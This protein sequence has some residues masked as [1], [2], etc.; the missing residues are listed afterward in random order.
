[1]ERSAVRIPV[2]LLVLVAYALAGTSLAQESAWTYAFWTDPASG[3]TLEAIQARSTG[4]TN[5]MAVIACGVDGRPLL[6]FAAR[7]FQ[8]L[9]AGD[10]TVA[11]A[12]DGGE[13][14]VGWGAWSRE[15]GGAVLRWAGD[16]E[17]L[18]PFLTELSPARTLAVS[19]QDASGAEL[20]AIV[21]D[22]RDVDVALAGLDCV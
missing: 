4:G 19:L 18:T 14:Q 2:H 7:A 12:L 13:P 1:M 5:G 11:T 9:A 17:A 8:D 3:E 15:A 22:V 21:L 20:A 16:D 6:A 10:T